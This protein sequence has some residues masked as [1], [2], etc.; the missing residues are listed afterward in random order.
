MGL[1]MFQF[2][3]CGFLPQS[4]NRTETDIFGAIKQQSIQKANDFIDLSRFELG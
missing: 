1:T 3:N 2:E 4:V